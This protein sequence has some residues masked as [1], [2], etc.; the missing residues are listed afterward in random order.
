[1]TT[2]IRIDGLAKSFGRTVALRP[3]DLEVSAGEV[4]GYL[5][6]NGASKT[7]TIRCLL[8]LVRAT[9]GRVETT[10]ARP[11]G[12]GSADAGPGR[13]AR[14][15]EARPGELA[16]ALV[17]GLGLTAFDRPAFDRRD[18]AP[19]WGL[20]LGARPGGSGLR[21]WDRGLSPLPA[22]A[23]LA[24]AGGSREETS[25]STIAPATQHQFA[26]E[27]P[28]VESPNPARTAA[29]AA[30]DALTATGLAVVVRPFRAQDAAD[31]RALLDGA[32]ERSRYFRFFGVSPRAGQQY[33]QRLQEPDQTTA[34]VVVVD[35]GRIVAIGSVHPC[36][37]PTGESSSTV[38][39]GV[40]VADERQGDGL[41][42]LVVEDLLARAHLL[43]AATVVAEV[44]SSNG[45]MLDLFQNS[46]FSVQA[47]R[48]GGEVDV[49]IDLAEDAATRRRVADRQAHAEVASLDHVL[50]PS[51]I[52]VVGAGKH[53][54]TVGR[55][56]LQHLVDADFGGQ[57]YAVNPDGVRVGAIP[58]YKRVRDIAQ[59]PDLVV[60]AV[61]AGAVVT[62]AGDCADSG[63]RALLTLTSGFS[64]AGGAEGQAA[65]LSLCRRAGMRLIGPNC[66]GVA[67]TDPEVRLD[68]TFLP[69]PVPPGTTAVLSQSGAS[70]IAIMDALSHRGAGASSLVTVGNKADI[71]GNDVLPWW[72]ADPRTKVIAAYLESIAEP[73]PF[74]RLAG[75]VTRSKPIVLLK[76]GRSA[77]A[78]AAASSHTA[79]AADDDAAVDALCRSANIIRVDD[80]RE[81]ADVSALGGM[82]PLPRG[83]RVAIVGNSGGPAVLA[84]DA[85]VRNGLHVATMSR[86]TQE[87]LR[88]VLPS[89]AAVRGPI[90]VTAGVGAK[91]LSH[92]LQLVA[93][94]PGVDV[95][96]AVLTVLPSL[97][98]PDLHDALQ[99]LNARHPQITV[100]ACVFGNDDRPWHGS[101]PRF[102]QPEDALRAVA[103][104]HRYA[105]R[106]TASASVH[107]GAAPAADLDLAAVRAIVSDALAGR[108]DSWLPA[109]ECYRVLGHCGITV[110]PFVTAEDATTAV[111][112][113]TRLTFPVVAKADGPDLVHKSDVGGVRLNLA[114]PEALRQAVHEMERT[115][116][117]RMQ[118]VIVQTQA[119]HGPEVIVGATRDPRFG[120]L[121]LVGRGGVDSDVDPDRVWG[122]APLTHTEAV[123]M[124]RSLRSAS[125]LSARRG[126]RASDVTALAE[127][128]R[129]VSRLM[130][131]VAEVA[132]IDLNPVLAGPDA[133]LV[134][135]VRIRVRRPPPPSLLDHVRHLR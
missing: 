94:D 110:A 114:T 127:V 101:V 70:A 100:A 10:G 37:S 34:A 44:M 19:A 67:N 90:D 125:G 38:E 89:S 106:R 130:S 118:G 117:E 135:D 46:G 77:A 109:A 112:A 111:E 72:A 83:R 66:I 51:S 30:Y 57:L 81:L 65:L 4:M 39:L 36:S 129:R 11:V 88:E 78:A 23:R 61:P 25:L 22:G 64:E 115:I 131:V 133:A 50:R 53:R 113:S 21:P 33:V 95:I 35:R 43:G 62:V 3:L 59:P 52:A 12:A 63:V 79:A 92:V 17:T 29:D 98:E 69:E 76:T 56:V 99:A 41:G 2:A 126:R 48:R 54:H 16:A 68:A 132:E 134:V 116:G 20:G 73:R 122:L 8:G 103:Q 93:D 9:S 71:G 55:Q 80:L 74:A 107:A 75:Q 6:P 97:T 58:G 60:L 47:D 42:T 49:S 84:A 28:D 96:L 40:L 45:A 128:V 120:P 32:S 87:R 105:R 13:F 1:V 108:G 91:E 119:G 5:G 7:T 27:P 82:Q 104:L 26:A 102:D 121:M 24:H 124:V 15:A 31:A 14:P 86:S 18:L 123:D 85:C